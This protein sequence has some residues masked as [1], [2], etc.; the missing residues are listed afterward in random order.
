MGRRPHSRS[1]AVWAN[2]LR[3]GRW[4][5]P[6]RGRMEFAYDPHWV[7]DAHAR[8]LSLSLPIDFDGL[9]VT[10]DKV[11]FFFENLLPDSESIRRRLRTRF[12][13]N[14]GSAFELLAALGRDCVGAVQLLPED[15]TPEGVFRIDV[16]PL[17]DKQV[18]RELLRTLSP[19]APPLG[20][21]D[22]PF[23]LSLAGAQEK[24]AFTWHDG[25]WGRP[26]G[27]T[28]TTH[29]FKL[30]LGLIGHESVDMSTSLENEWLCGQLL[31]AFG[32]PV[33]ASEVRRFGATKALVVTRFDR[34]LHDSG[35]YWLRLPQEDMCQATGTPPWA[36]YESDGGPGLP[37]VARVL[38]G[39]TTREQDL[40]TLLQA[41][42]LFWMLAAT[43]GHAKNFSLHLLPGGRYRLAPLYDVISLWPVAG[44]KSSQIHPKKLHLA[45]S[46]RSKNR[47]RRLTDIRRYHF[48]ATARQC[49]LGA[50]MGDLI[51]ETLARVPHAIDEVAS[52]L[53]RRFP[54]QVFES[55][56]DGL[57]RS[58]AELESQASKA[59]QRSTAA[60]GS[61]AAKGR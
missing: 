47:Q 3:M 46:L 45:M 29:I 42:L 4:L 56:T 7:A 30:P 27:A 23:R 28:P 22:V 12:G 40:K 24:T 50:A 52:R 9:P 36:R 49:G 57:R 21:D 17:T 26:L 16:E 13:L 6:A 38:W 58:A 35:A 20:D 39:S 54:P 51:D 19:T 34:R 2:G 44:P 32:L 8:P 61:T 59:T 48:D 18:E 55:I 37:E 41:Q 5:V 25:R 43:D 1:L 14:T 11:G 31:A 15:E 10:G 33:A 53:P 60:Q